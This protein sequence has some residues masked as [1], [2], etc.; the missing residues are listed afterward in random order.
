[1]EVSLDNTYNMVIMKM[2]VMIL[3]MIMIMII[4]MKIIL[5]VTQSIFKLRP[6]DFAW[7]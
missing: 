1:M 3:M 5:A 6:P 4:M 7:K 2:T